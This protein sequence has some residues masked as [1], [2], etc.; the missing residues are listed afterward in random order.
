MRGR[1]WSRHDLSGSSAAG[2]AGRGAESRGGR[3]R[4]TSR[5]PSAATA[6]RFTKQ[7]PPSETVQQRRRPRPPGERGTAPLRRSGNPMSRTGGAA[8]VTVRPERSLARH[9]PAQ[10]R[11]A[12][13]LTYPAGGWLI[14]AGRRSGALLCGWSTHSPAPSRSRSRS[15]V[16]AA[17]G[18]RARAATTSPARRL[19]ARRRR[20]RCRCRLSGR[21]PSAADRAQLVTQGHNQLVHGKKPLP[22]PETNGARAP[23]G[24]RRR[25]SD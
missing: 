18:G 19:S 17:A 12:A 15:H 3:P 11:P 4:R 25:L 1:R 14:G 6:D 24:S 8:N 13:S 21:P 23:V 7:Q 10:L 9:R 22:V 5:P 16:P 20:R 2:S